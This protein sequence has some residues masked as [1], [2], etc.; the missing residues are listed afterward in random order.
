MTAAGDRAHWIRR[1]FAHH[2]RWWRRWHR[3]RAA[4][5]TALVHTLRGSSGQKTCREKKR[6]EK[7]SRG[8]GRPDRRLQDQRSGRRSL[9]L[10]FS[11]SRHAGDVVDTEMAPAAV[12]IEMQRL[13][14][15]RGDERGRL[16][17]WRRR[18]RT[19]CSI[20]RRT[21]STTGEETARAIHRQRLFNR[22]QK[23]PQSVRCRSTA[24]HSETKKKKT[25]N[26]T[27]RTSRHYHHRSPFLPLSLF[28]PAE[29]SA[30]RSPA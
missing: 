12:H 17:H 4:A 22:Q 11:L 21:H 27:R 3:R 16:G 20:C 29:P 10:V 13:S 9:S 26:S 1:L 8:G 7:R 5:S 18:L 14:S 28:Q 15:R 23:R 25:L 30:A 2:C 6:R 24:T 19:F